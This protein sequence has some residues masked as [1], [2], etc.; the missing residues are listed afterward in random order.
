MEK[1]EKDGRKKVVL[2]VRMLRD[3]LVDEFLF[4]L[5]FFFRSGE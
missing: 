2:Y 5:I 1:E 3:V 4:L